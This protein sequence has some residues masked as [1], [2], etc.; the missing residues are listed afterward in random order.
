MRALL[1]HRVLLDRAVPG[2]LFVGLLCHGEREREA[3]DEGEDE[4]QVNRRARRR[5]RQQT[6]RVRLRPASAPRRVTLDT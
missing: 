4:L 1:V 5:D 2:R 6:A 3:G